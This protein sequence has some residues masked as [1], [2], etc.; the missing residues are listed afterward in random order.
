MKD[1]LLDSEFDFR[2]RTK[3]TDEGKTRPG[4]LLLDMGITASK[5]YKYTVYHKSLKKK[6]KKGK[7]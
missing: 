2:N 3:N 5:Q 1:V 7:E 4:K 6:K